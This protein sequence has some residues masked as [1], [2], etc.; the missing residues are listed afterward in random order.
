MCLSVQLEFASDNMLA[1]NMSYPNEYYHEI[2]SSWL[3]KR[4]VIQHILRGVSGRVAVD[5]CCRCRDFIIPKQ[6]PTILFIP[7]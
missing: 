5:L 2:L 4:Q 3:S 7:Q 1:H 6:K